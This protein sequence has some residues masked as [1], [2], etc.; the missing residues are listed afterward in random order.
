MT[1]ITTVE[2]IPILIISHPSAVWPGARH[3]HMHETGRMLAIS[4]GDPL[5]AAATRMIEEGYGRSSV[6]VIRDA[7][8]EVADISGTI[9]DAL[10]GSP[11][12]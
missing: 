3:L 1:D 9:A 8:D 4:R 6:L 2:P 11:A 7:N 12:G 5:R 10:A